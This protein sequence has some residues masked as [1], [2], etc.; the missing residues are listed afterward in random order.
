MMRAR[1]SLLSV[2]CMLAYSSLAAE[3]PNMADVMSA[4]GA[5]L[6]GGATNAAAVVDFRE[7]KGLLPAELTGMKRTNA[8]G[9]KS[10]AMGMTVAVA[11]GRYE[12][13]DDSGSSIDIK[14][15]DMGGTGGMM[16]FMQYGW[17]SAEVDRESDTG[18]ERT[19]TIAGHKAMEKYDTADKHGETQ[20]LVNKRFMVEVSGSNVTADQIKEAVGKL[21]LSKLAGLQPK[22]A[23]TP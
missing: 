18:Y 4:M 21:D 15:S 19:T 10:G 17:A 2:G 13:T 7:L 8:S 5:M 20:I 22:P 9:E 3:G 6:G 11:E 12:A 14:I 23:P 1:F 16:S